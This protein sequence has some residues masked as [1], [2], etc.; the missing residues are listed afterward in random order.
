MLMCILDISPIKYTIA[1]K[2]YENLMCLD[3]PWSKALNP[4]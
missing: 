4:V 1:G 2:V 3:K